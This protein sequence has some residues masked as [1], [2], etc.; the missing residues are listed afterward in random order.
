M[1]VVI[2]DVAYKKVSDYIGAITK[3][4]IKVYNPIKCGNQYL[5]SGKWVLMV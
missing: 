4:T 1:G 2:R 3:A 5:S